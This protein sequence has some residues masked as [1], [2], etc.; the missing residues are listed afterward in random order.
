VKIIIT[1][2]FE[3]S[4][5]KLPPEIKERSKD[6]FKLLLKDASHPSLRV[7]KVRKYEGVFECR[8][9]GDYRLLFSITKEAYVF[10][11]VGNHNEI[12]R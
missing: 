7:K 6:K 11:E 12:L 4:F 8:I 2:R 1:R 5:R 10:L 3:R 9:T